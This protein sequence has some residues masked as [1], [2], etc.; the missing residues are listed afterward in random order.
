MKDSMDP[1]RYAADLEKVVTELALKSRQI[2]EAEGK[3]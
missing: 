3:K 2:R 1:Q